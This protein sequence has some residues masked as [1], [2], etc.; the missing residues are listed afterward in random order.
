MAVLSSGNN[1]DNDDDEEEACATSN[2]RRSEVD[3]FEIIIM[4]LFRFDFGWEV[5]RKCCLFG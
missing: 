4:L 3:L 2:A 5:C 1:T